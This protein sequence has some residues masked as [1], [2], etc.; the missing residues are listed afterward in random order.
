MEFVGTDCVGSR[1]FAE[2]TAGNER[3]VSLLYAEWV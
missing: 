2:K 1:T 3:Y